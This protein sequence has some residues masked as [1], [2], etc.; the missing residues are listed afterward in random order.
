MLG[1]AVPLLVSIKATPLNVNVV[2]SDTED[3]TEEEASTSQPTAH[4][5]SSPAKP[6]LPTALVT[7]SAT[8]TTGM[9]NAV[10]HDIARKALT[11]PIARKY[12]LGNLCTY[13]ESMYASVQVSISL[14]SLVV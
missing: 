14:S 4:K 12:N 13:H 2:P 9:P 7:D 5:A 3:N 8:A 10:S 6:D 11:R 1:S